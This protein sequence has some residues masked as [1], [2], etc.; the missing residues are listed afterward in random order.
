MIAPSEPEHALKKMRSSAPEPAVE[1]QPSNNFSFWDSST[2]P[3]TGITTMQ[4]M[5]SDQMPVLLTAEVV[6]HV[7][8]PPQQLILLDESVPVFPTSYNAKMM[9]IDE[10][11]RKALRRMQHRQLAGAFDFYAGAVEIL[12][13]RRQTLARMIAEVC[14]LVV[15]RV[16]RR[17]LL[18]VWNLFVDTVR[19]THNRRGTVRKAQRRMQ[20]R[21][22]ADAFDFYAKAVEVLVAQRKTCNPPAGSQIQ[23]AIHTCC[24]MVLQT[25]LLFVLVALVVDLLHTLSTYKHAY[26]RRLA[27]VV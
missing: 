21:Q 11:A 23:T 17:E 27:L 25:V 9:I 5:N 4:G 19:E 7:G 10:A 18:M 2:D 3:T 1:T 24:R 14:N 6:S 16:R 12:L 22:L 15:H 13:A 20:H 8:I 26:P